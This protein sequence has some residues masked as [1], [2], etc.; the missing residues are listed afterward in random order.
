MC[1][2][3]VEVNERLEESNIF[4]ISSLQWDDVRHEYNPVKGGQHHGEHH[5]EGGGVGRDRGEG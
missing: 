4:S 3:L 1:F 5:D 2:C